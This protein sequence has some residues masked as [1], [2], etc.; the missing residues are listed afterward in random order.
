MRL[1]HSILWLS[2]RLTNEWWNNFPS[3]TIVPIDQKNNLYIVTI[4]APSIKLYYFPCSIQHVVTGPIY[5]STPRSHTASIRT[6]S[7]FVGNSRLPTVTWFSYLF[8]TAMV[9]SQE[10][11]CMDEVSSSQTAVQLLPKPKIRSLHRYTVSPSTRRSRRS[12]VQMATWIVAM[13]QN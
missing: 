9:H 4:W 12:T 2:C 8:W 6:C 1:L 3:C 10:Y 7:W 11:Q 13:W 5:Y